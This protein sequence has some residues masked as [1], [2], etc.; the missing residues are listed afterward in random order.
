MVS[1]GSPNAGI[2]V[3]AIGSAIWY[4]GLGGNGANRNTNVN[5]YPP[6]LTVNN[7]AP[8]STRRCRP[9]LADPIIFSARSRRAG[10]FR[11]RTC[12]WPHRPFA[13]GVPDAMPR[14]VPPG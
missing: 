3:V 10:R 13:P 14:W 9:S 2:V 11:F 8:A 5:V 6:Q 1:Q 12:F 7:P 4:F